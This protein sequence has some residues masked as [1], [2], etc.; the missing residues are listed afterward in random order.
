MGAATVALAARPRP[1]HAGEFTGRIK[2][3]LK[4]GMIRER[5]SV[6]EKMKLIK[7]LGFDG[8]EPGVGDKVDPAELRDAAR[9]AAVEIHGVGGVYEGA[10]AL[11]G[12]TVTFGTL[13]TDDTARL[14]VVDL[15]TRSRLA[16]IEI[17]GFLGL[18]VLGGRRV[19]VD[20][21]HRTV[22]VFE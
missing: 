10:Q 5:V 16:G 13:S 18:D 9:A 4:Y 2:K 6:H 7:D 22:A 8:V 20:T 1:V 14:R 3:A 15:S 19:V 17:S 11:S 21:V 12:V